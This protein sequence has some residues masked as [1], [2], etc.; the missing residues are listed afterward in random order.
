VLAVRARNPP[1]HAT[2]ATIALVDQILL[3]NS[4]LSQATMP[5]EAQLDP[6]SARQ[7]LS[8]TQLVQLLAPPA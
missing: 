1:I 4:Q 2:L 5:L 6:S 7:V 8:A 3:S